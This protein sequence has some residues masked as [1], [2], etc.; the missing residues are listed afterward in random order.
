[1]SE[2]GALLTFTETAPVPVGSGNS[3]RAPPTRHDDTLIGSSGA[4]DVDLLAGHDSFGALSG[5]DKV[6]GGSGRDSIFGDT[7]ND[8]LYGG[9]E[10]DLLSGSTGNDLLLGGEGVDTAEGGAGDDVYGVDSSLDR[11]IE[12]A[13]GGHDRVQSLVHW[14]LG[15]Q[16]EDL[17][18]LGTAALRGEGNS[19]NN[20]LQGNDGDNTL[21]G[22]DGADIL[23]GSKGKD[24]LIGGAG[25]DVL[26]GGQDRDADH[27]VFHDLSDGGL[28]AYRDVIHDFR[29]LTDV[30]DLRLIDANTDKPGNQ[31]FHFAGSEGR[32]HALWWADIGQDLLLRMDVNG[33]GQ[34]DM[35]IRLVKL[36]QIPLNDLLL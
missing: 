24:I 8:S 25:R 18:L 36:G 19:R 6:Q 2:L 12:I 35:E 11:V 28:G 26:Y 33:D 29:R 1:L 10:D 31:R 5:D 34:A 30:I 15:A 27:F 23:L 21:K 3:G 9:T 22:H 20:R 16:L 14:V 4:D 13:R 17:R 7:G 32:A